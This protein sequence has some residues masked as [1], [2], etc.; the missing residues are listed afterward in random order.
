M[1]EQITTWTVIAAVFIPGLSLAF[2]FVFQH[3]KDMKAE[4]TKSIED[5]EKACIKATDEVWAAINE[6]RRSF[7]E[8]RLQDARIYVDRGGLNSLKS[9]LDKRLDDIA[10]ALKQITAKIGG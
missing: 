5:T 6:L 3:M 8:A 7:A 9:D 2:R 10:A 4:L 1:G